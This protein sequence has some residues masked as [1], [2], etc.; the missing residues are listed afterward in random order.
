MYHRFKKNLLLLFLFFSGLIPSVFSQ[1]Q[2][3]ALCRGEAA[4]LACLKKN[5]QELLHTDYEQFSSILQETEPKAASC[6]DLSET[7]RFLELITVRPRGAEF[8]EYIH[9]EVENLCLAK[10]SCCLDAALFLD[11]R[12]QQGLMSSLKNPLFLE[13]A[14]LSKAFL[15][16]KDKKKY[17]KLLQFYFSR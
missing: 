11:E 14:V 2:N 7:G 5:F 16:Y 12:A 15:P 8:G 9:E 17:K 4:T 13:E 3:K 1:A 6:A 10:V